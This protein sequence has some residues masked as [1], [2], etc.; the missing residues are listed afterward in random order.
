L[1]ENTHI[2]WKPYRDSKVLNFIYDTLVPWKAG[3]GT[4][5]IN[6]DLARV[7]R[8]TTQYFD[9]LFD[10]FIEKSI[11]KGPA[12]LVHYVNNL[13]ATRAYALQAVQEMFRDATAINEEVA[14][15]AHEAVQKLA[16]IKLASTLVLTGM[17]CGVALSGAGVALIAQASGVK[18]AYD[19][20][21]DIVKPDLAATAKGIGYD[22]EKILLDIGSDHLKEHVAKAGEHALKESEGKLDLAIQRINRYSAQLAKH[23]RSK[24]AIKITRRLGSAEADASFAARHAQL[25]KTAMKGVKFVG[26][27][28]PVVFATWDAIDAIKEYHEDLGEE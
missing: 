13:V 1:Q 15:T 3:P 24:K 19:L 8:L 21:L 9:H 23:I 26:K 16:A 7:N 12:D 5:E 10:I 27:A 20:S 11:T 28:L 6:Q 4:A 18:F 22:S 14:G 2:E 17:S 25:A